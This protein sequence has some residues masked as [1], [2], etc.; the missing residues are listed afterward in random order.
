[1]ANQMLGVL[2]GMGPLAS[3]EFLKTIYERSDAEREQELPRVILYS[4]P[5]FPD[6]TEMFLKGEDDL[7]LRSLTTALRRLVALGAS[8]IVIC[9]V[10]MH[11]LLS[12]LPNELRGRTISLIDVIFAQ[13]REQTRKHLVICSIGTRKLELFQ[14]HSEWK[15]AGDKFVFL[16]DEEQMIVHDLIYQIKLKHGMQRSMRCLEWL[17]RKHDLDSF[18]VGCTEAH[19]LAKQ[20]MNS[21]EARQRYRCIDP[22]SV[23]AGDWGKGA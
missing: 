3:A 20:F 13:M 15:L 16:E 9:C 7:L 8:E 6:R 14:K 17:L 4:D 10:T 11:H 12:R 2:G 18:I 22:L 1:M 21:T 23:I 19:I 5:T